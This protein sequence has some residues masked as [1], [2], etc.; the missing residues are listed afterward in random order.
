MIQ[1]TVLFCVLSFGLQTLIQAYEVASPIAP[2]SESSIVFEV[3]L[4]KKTTNFK[5][6]KVR[7]EIIFLLTQ[8]KEVDFSSD[9]IYLFQNLSKVSSLPRL[10]TKALGRSLAKFDLMIRIDLASQN[11][12]DKKITALKNFKAKL[13]SIT[14]S[15]RAVKTNNFQLFSDGRPNP[16][17]FQMCFVLPWHKTRNRR[18][19][20]RYWLYEHGPY[21]K[22]VVKFTEQD[23][24][25]SYTQLHVDMNVDDMLFDT[26]IQGY[27]CQSLSDA[28]SFKLQMINPYAAY[29]S[30]TIN[31][32]LA[33]DE[34]N[35]SN[36]PYMAIFRD[37]HIE[38]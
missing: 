10:M 38:F 8:I 35:F 36:N 16:R 33:H 3:D 11:L 5:R 6:K 14:D 17:N 27:A 20:Q 32:V 1:K 30:L 23:L 24:I 4:P 12:S 18:E 13:I 21:A 29:K 19:S 26:D 28:T 15:V 31:G 34:E 22:E 37:N 7:D 25:K 9:K 2:M